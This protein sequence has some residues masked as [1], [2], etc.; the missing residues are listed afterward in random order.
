MRNQLR[1]SVMGPLIIS[2]TSSFL[3]WAPGLAN[4]TTEGPPSAWYHFPTL[5]FQFHFWIYSRFKSVSSKVLHIQ[6]RHNLGQVEN[7]FGSLGSTEATYLKR[8]YHLR[9]STNLTFSVWAWILENFRKQMSIMQYKKIGW[10]FG[11]PAHFGLKYQM[12]LEIPIFEFIFELL[13]VLCF[14]KNLFNE[15][16][17]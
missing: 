14:Y 8:N 9:T 11:S 10:M 4:W 16:H 6:F 13:I 7:K 15:E 3:P 1:N 17:L 12:K 5:I 2:T